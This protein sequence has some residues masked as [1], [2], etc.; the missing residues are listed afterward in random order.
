MLITLEI[1]AKSF[2]LRLKDEWPLM[3]DELAPP[4]IAKPRGLA[5][6]TFPFILRDLALPIVEFEE[7]RLV[8][9]AKDIAW[10]LVEAKARQTCVLGGDYFGNAAVRTSWRGVMVRVLTDYDVKTNA[11]ETHIDVGYA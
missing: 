8:P 4:L 2:L 11:R 7:L 10:Q 9:A 3:A 1:V 5:T 6:F